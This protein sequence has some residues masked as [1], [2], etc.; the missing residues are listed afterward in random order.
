M[1]FLIALVLRV[2]ADW[3]LALYSWAYQVDTPDNLVTAMAGWIA[4]ET[5]A[6]GVL[7]RAYIA[8]RDK[9]EAFV[10]ATL[11]RNL[12]T[13]QENKSAIDD[14]TELVKII[15]EELRIKKRGENRGR[16][17]KAS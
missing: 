10:I 13:Q 9:F 5:T 16:N 14:N 15:A 7:G 1:I 3:L 4:L 6:L 17:T 12:A 2:Q 8:Q 11:E